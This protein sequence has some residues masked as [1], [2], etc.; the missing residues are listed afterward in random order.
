MIMPSAFN[1]IPLTFSPS[2]FQGINWSFPVASGKWIAG[3][4]TFVTFWHY[5]PTGIEMAIF[6]PIPPLKL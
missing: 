2:G 6:F 5:F 4:D 1:A 3:S